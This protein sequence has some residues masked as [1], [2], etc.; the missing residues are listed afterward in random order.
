[1]S[2]PH[3]FATTLEVE[4]Q[5]VPKSWQLEHFALNTGDNVGH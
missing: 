4:T 3:G 1:M 2:A 5:P